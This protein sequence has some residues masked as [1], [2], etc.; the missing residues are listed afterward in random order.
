MTDPDP[1]ETLIVIVIYIFERQ[2]ISLK[3]VYPISTVPI[4]A[5]LSPTITARYFGRSLIRNRNGPTQRRLPHMDTG[6]P[7][8]TNSVA[9]L[10]L[11]I[12]IR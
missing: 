12:R 4:Y 5:M 9:L 8:S 6:T 1:G 10:V 3:Q 7:P 11:R 2:N